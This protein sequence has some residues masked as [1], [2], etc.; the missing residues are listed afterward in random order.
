ME[1]VLRPA[2]SKNYILRRLNLVSGIPKI[3][4]GDSKYLLTFIYFEILLSK[5]PK[6]IPK[7]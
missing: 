7:K 5:K 2:V 6:E 4:T 1:Y 3:L